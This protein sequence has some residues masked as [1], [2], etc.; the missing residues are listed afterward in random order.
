MAT[1]T[2]RLDPE[3][4]DKLEALAKAMDRSRSWLVADAVRRYIEEENWQIA[5]IAEGVRLADAGDFASDEE[6]R[7]AF[8]EWGVNVD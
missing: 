7:Q 6:V 1:V 8:G 4:H 3:T 2:T 5:A